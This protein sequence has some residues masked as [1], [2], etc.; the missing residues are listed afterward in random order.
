MLPLKLLPWE[1][2]SV[3][4]LMKVVKTLWFGR[5][6]TPPHFWNQKYY[7]G[8]LLERRPSPRNVISLHL[9]GLINKIKMYQ[10]PWVTE[11]TQREPL[12][13]HVEVQNT[14]KSSK[15]GIHHRYHQYVGPK[16]RFLHWRRD[17][18]FSSLLNTNQLILL[19]R[20]FSS[21]S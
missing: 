19:M 9:R 17:L 14:K 15:D 7:P 8:N 2:P 18:Q 11:R 1:V 13:L 16:K 6:S 21:I 5:L 12:H 3:L 10:S 20:T 4:R